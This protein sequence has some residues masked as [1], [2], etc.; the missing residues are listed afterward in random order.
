MSYSL[1]APGR[2]QGGL[3][4]KTN[5]PKFHQVYVINIMI[6]NIFMK[7][8]NVLLLFF[9]FFEAVILGT[10]DPIY[11]IIIDK[12]SIQYLNNEAKEFISFSNYKN[13]LWEILFYIRQSVFKKD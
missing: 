3:L 9:N 2:N 4:F 10:I 13:P 7:H 8:F 5:G 12:A 11:K 6:I 1:T